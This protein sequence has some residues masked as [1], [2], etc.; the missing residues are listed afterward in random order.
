MKAVQIK[1]DMQQ[2]PTAAS[3]MR[4]DNHA[5]LNAIVIRGPGITIMED[6]V[7]KVKN[8]VA[9]CV[10]LIVSRSFMSVSPSKI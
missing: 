7:T 10:M 8:K 3:D 5:A 2:Q 9:I 1:N 4:I 6:P